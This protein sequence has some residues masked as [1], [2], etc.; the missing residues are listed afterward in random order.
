MVMR[1]FWRRLGNEMEISTSL[2]VWLRGEPQPERQDSSPSEGRHG[3]LLFPPSL[4][5]RFT[6][7]AAENLEPIL[8]EVQAR[9]S[10]LSGLSW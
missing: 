4:G 3:T 1:A 10:G 2:L 6:K 5:F 9:T 7:L 8:L